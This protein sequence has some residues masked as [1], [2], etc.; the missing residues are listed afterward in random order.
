MKTLSSGLI[1]AGLVRVAAWSPRDPLSGMV[2][3]G[4]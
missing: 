2:R 4:D 3:D 1:N